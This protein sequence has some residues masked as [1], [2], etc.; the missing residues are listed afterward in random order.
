V[1]RRWI[2]FCAEA[3]LDSDP[4]LSS[5][6]MR[7]ARHARLLSLYRVAKWSPSGTILGKRPSPWFRQ[8]C[9]MPQAAAASFRASNGAPSTSK[10]LSYYPPSSPFEGVRQHGPAAERQKAMLEVPP[11]VLHLPITNTEGQGLSIDARR[12]HRAELSFRD[13]ILRIHKV[14]AF[15]TDQA[16]EDGMLCVQDSVRRVLRH[17]SRSPASRVC[18]NRIRRSE[19]TEEMDARTQRRSGHKFL[20]PVLR[21]GSAIRRIIATIPDWNE[22]TTLCSVTLEGRPSSGNAFVRKLLRHTCSLYSGI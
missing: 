18:H 21:W 8:L 9:A 7:P 5:Y 20:C 2:T 19:K 4:F 16:S 22:Q 13:A 3:G 10:A 15:R 1:W 17:R 11:K 6:S 12:R 14:R